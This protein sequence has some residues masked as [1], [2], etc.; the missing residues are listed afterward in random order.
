MDDDEKMPFIIWV[1]IILILIM[2]VV[3]L[4]EGEPE[5]PTD[6]RIEESSNE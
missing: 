4:I 5:K 3:A 6:V 1:V 2:C